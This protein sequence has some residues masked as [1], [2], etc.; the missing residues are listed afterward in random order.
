[1]AEQGP[2][3]A[4]P[5]A[6]P[7]TESQPDLD[8]DAPDQNRK[9]DPFSVSF[10]GLTATLLAITAIATIGIPLWF[11]Q[12]HITLD[13]AA[14]LLVSD[15]EDVR[16]WSVL[17]HTECT[18]EFDADGGGYSAIDSLGN[19]LTSPMGD[20]PFRRD[21][22]AD[23]VFRG[24]E[25]ANLDLDRATSLAFSRRGVP[26]SQGTITLSYGGETRTIQLFGGRI[27][28]K[29]APEED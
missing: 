7:V 29:D 8:A 14:K 17:S 24:V 27:F 2:G 21:Y 15:L 22:D 12:P 11:S 19:F 3:T 28:V 26:S 9:K 5:P 6:H 18:I 1:M 4:L 10:F 13:K 16:Q 20:G 23:A 25:I